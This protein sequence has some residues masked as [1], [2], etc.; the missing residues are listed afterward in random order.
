[1]SIPLRR[2]ERL[3]FQPKPPIPTLHLAWNLGEDQGSAVCAMHLVMFPDT[4]STVA[5]WGGTPRFTHARGGACQETPKL[6][7]RIFVATGQFL[8]SP[9]SAGHQDCRSARSGW[10][11][12]HHHSAVGE[13]NGIR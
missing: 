5:H 7:P 6:P 11:A 10:I 13:Q 9:D 4:R 3:D 1:M 12:V 8:M 2:R